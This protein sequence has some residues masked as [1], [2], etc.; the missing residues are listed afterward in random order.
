MFKV[1]SGSRAEKAAQAAYSLYAEQIKLAFRK[2]LAGEKTT[3]S[4]VSGSCKAILNA[5]PSR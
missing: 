5:S 2:G 1:D 3:Q 4:D